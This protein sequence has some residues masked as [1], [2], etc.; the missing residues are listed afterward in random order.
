M[1]ELGEYELPAGWRWSTIPGLVGAGGVFIDGDWVESKDQDPG[2]D[3]RLVQLADVGD[4]AYRD[5]SSRFLTSAKASELG[6]TFL[7]TGDV[8]V[9]RMPDPLGRACIFPGDSKPSVTV[10]DVCIVRS[11]NGEFDHR[12]L[13][14]FVNAHPF[15][16]AIS[17]LQAGSTRKRISRGNLATIPLP[18]PPPAEQHRI[19]A[20]IEKQFTRLD[21]GVAALRRAQANLKRYRASVLKAACE[22]KLVPTEAELARAE[23]R[24]YESGAALLERILAERR[25]SWAGR[26]KYKEPAAP[27]V[28]G[29]SELPEGWC[30]SSL[31]QAFNVEVG[32]TPSRKEASYWGGGVPWVSSGEVAFCR[33]GKTRETISELGLANTSTDVHPIGTVLIGMIGEGKTRGQVAI[34]DIAA[35]NNQN[36][37]AIRVSEAGLVPE[38]VYH[39]LYSQY[40]RNR[41]LGSGNNQPALNKARVQAIPMP[42]PPLAEQQRIVSEVERRLSV[43]D[44]LE[45][46]V[47]ANLLRAA[48]LRQAVLQRAFSGEK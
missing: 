25:K 35:C 45:A 20:E 46:V 17:G 44:E 22:G 33:I 40:D 6:C 31:G 11:A 2:G 30:W 37:A 38:F 13:S 21:A 10:V 12:W 1:S 42:L 48:R 43:I 34:L 9:A 18:V 7:N 41:G 23:G 26:G 28:A 5:K 39:Y 15:R 24:E 32:A 16:S 3:V 47:S 8:L 4:G 36:S 29:L 27:D 14:W 19:V